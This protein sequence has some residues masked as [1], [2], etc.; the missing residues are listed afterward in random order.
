MQGPRANI[1]G[2]YGMIVAQ[3]RAPLFYTA[4]DVPDTV[5]GRFDMIVLHVYLVSRRLRTAG[6]AA[7]AI[8]QEVFD[9][10][11]QDMDASMRELGV[12]DL[13]VPKK[14]RAMGEA[15]YGRAGAYDA[16]IDDAGKLA[17]ALQ[18]NVFAGEAAAAVNA[19]RLAAYV[20]AADAGLASQE[21]DA[22]IRGEAVF[23]KPEEIAA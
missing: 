5:E 3:A 9:L 17:A 6:A 18:R 23:P 11:F 20:Q 19:R 15:F 1:R 10:F 13:S 2:L 7:R 22:V 16:A 21:A 8:S 14:I 12:G 4:Y